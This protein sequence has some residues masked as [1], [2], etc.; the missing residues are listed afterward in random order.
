MRPPD[1]QLPQFGHRSH[2]IRPARRR[3]GMKQGPDIGA[4][5]SVT[6]WP[7]FMLCRVAPGSMPACE[8]P[9]Q[10]MAVDEPVSA[11]AGTDAAQLANRT[12]RSVGFSAGGP[13]ST[14]RPRRPAQDRHRGTVRFQELPK[15]PRIRYPFSEIQLQSAAFAGLAAVRAGNALV[16][17]RCGPR[18]R[19]ETERLTRNRKSPA[20]RGPTPVRHSAAPPNRA[21]A[22]AWHA[23]RGSR[24]VIRR[25][26]RFGRSFVPA[27]VG[28]FL[29]PAMFF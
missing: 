22:D 21:A 18:R 6:A 7:H 23:L 27:Q 8:G 15:R 2:V 17:C 28:T 9:H 14:V 1:G 11:L 10:H 4:R 25:E 19:R 12:R 20:P 3:Q 26:T 29:H 16:R 5:F 24:R 13:A